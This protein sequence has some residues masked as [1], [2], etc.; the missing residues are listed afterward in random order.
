MGLEFD[1]AQIESKLAELEK[2]TAKEITDKALVEGAK[3]LLKEQLENVPRDTGKLAESLVVGKI[4]GSGAKRKVL[5]GISP[6][7]YDEVRYGFYQEHGTEVML[8][9]KW[10]KKSWIQSNKKAQQKVG[11]S[12]ARDLGGL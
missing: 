6:S 10:M 4:S 9:K 12:L 3:I 8:G 2:K 5:V 7:M 1:F 11:E